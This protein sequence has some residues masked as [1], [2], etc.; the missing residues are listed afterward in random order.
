MKK[1]KI[2][3]QLPRLMTGGLSVDHRG[4]VD[5]V[6][7]FDFKNI[8]RFYVVSNHKAGMVRAWHGH[9][10]EAKY[11]YVLSGTALVGAVG[12]DNWENPSKEYKVHQ[13]ILSSKKPAILYIPQGYVNGFKSLTDDAKLMFFST[14]TLEQTLKDD[15]RFDAEFWNIW[16]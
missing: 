2:S 6:N 11:V 13:F 16:S 14:K 9:K 12:I 1:I 5:F 15:I 4:E 10:Y 8:K 7:E 3:L